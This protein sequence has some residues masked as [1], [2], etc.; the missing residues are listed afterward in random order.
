MRTLPAGHGSDKLVGLQFLL[1]I[2][3]IAAA[4]IRAAA[5]PKPR[6]TWFIVYLVGS[7]LRGTLLWMVSSSPSRYFDVYRFTEPCITALWIAMSVELYAQVAE[8]YPG[9]SRRVWVSM[10]LT[11]G[12]FI[13]AAT[14]IEPHSSSLQTIILFRRATATILA[15]AIVALAC[16]FGYFRNSLRP[17]LTRH[18]A[19]MAFYFV[20]QAAASMG[21]NL[22]GKMVNWSKVGEVGAIVS[23]LTWA[24][25]LTR[26]GQKRTPL[27]RKF[28]DAEIAQATDESLQE[29]VD[30]ATKA[31]RGSRNSPD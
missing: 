10:A 26:A 15:I 11:V 1:P 13:T 5:L 9:L 25:V 24:V 16:L 20:T 23:Y 22:T 17:N 7:V 3:A 4:A 28:S 6:F 29:I 14:I 19:I 18:A 12:V 21:A 31:G 27:T 2:L 30:I 8:L